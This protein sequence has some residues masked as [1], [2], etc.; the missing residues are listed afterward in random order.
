MCYNYFVHS[1]VFEVQFNADQRF[2][3][4]TSTS[5]WWC[6]L[7]DIALI[8]LAERSDTVSPVCVLI[9]LFVKSWMLHSWTLVSLSVFQGERIEKGQGTWDP[10]EEPPPYVTSLSWLLFSFSFVTKHFTREMEKKDKTSMQTLQLLLLQCS[11]FNFYYMYN[12]IFFHI[13]VLSTDL[14]LLREW[15]LL[16]DYKLKVMGWGVQDICFM[17]FFALF[18]GLL[19]F[20]CCFFWIWRVFGRWRKGTQDKSE[21]VCHTWGPEETYIKAAAEDLRG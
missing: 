4:Q 6:G 3:S 8:V 9:S 10:E 14:I 1:K 19:R 18:H 12:S 7:T 15:Y 5:S 16:R 17:A 2:F 13:S 11:W 20:F 21:E